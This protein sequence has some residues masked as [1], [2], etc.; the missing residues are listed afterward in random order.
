MNQ[1]QPISM[2]QLEDAA[3]EVFNAEGDRKR[4]MLLQFAETQR[5][6]VLSV[7]MLSQDGVDE[8]M[9]GHVLDIFL[10]LYL[11]CLKAGDKLST[12]TQSELAVAFRR[13]ASRLDFLMNEPDMHMWDKVIA[14]HPEP[15]LS[16]FVFKHLSDTGILGKTEPEYKS[17]LIIQGV[18]EALT[19][20]RKNAAGINI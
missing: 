14:S 13:V 15:H 20:A 17:I 18:L 10:V 7:A 3:C 2:E 9:H 5:D 1:Y 4:Q 11:S 16:E 12:V 8:T 6:L 19:D